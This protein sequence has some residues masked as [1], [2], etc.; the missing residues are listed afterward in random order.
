MFLGFPGVSGVKNLPANAGGY[1]V[2]SPVQEEPT[3]HG[4]TMPMHN[5]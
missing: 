1:K 5:N 2:P 4:A 3:G